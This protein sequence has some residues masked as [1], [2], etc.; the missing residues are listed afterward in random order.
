MRALLAARRGHPAFH[1]AAPQ[2]VVCV[3]GPVLAL[4]RGPR[5]GRSVVALHNL[6]A[7]PQR[8]DP[9]RLGLDAGPHHDLVRR[10]DV[11][12]GQ[13]RLGAYEVRWLDATG[14]PSY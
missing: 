5:H 13:L 11:A 3:D 1:P 10:E 7:A 4:R 12:P 2:E 6:G 14:G 8:V 9:A